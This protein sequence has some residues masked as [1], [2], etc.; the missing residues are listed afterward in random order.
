MLLYLVLALGLLWTLGAGLAV[1][2]CVGTRR[3]DEDLA[4]RQGQTSGGGRFAR[5]MLAEPSL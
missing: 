2:L 3:I 4:A 1:V 5:G